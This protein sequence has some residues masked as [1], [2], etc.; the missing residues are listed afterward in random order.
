MID[1]LIKAEYIIKKMD[2]G[3]V[4]T[5]AKITLPYHGEQSFS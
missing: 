4:N 3:G 1:T 2:T 5:G